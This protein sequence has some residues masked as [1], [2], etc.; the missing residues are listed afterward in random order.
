MR[1]DIK[2]HFVPGSLNKHQH[3]NKCR[4][5]CRARLSF[6]P[7]QSRAERRQLAG[8]NATRANTAV[9]QVAYPPRCTRKLVRPLSGE[10]F[11]MQ[12]QSSTVIAFSKCGA[13]RKIS[14]VK[15]EWH[16]LSAL[17]GAG[18]ERPDSSFALQLARCLNIRRYGLKQK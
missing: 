3:I 9:T 17:L 11:R 13:I 15:Y 7:V 10:G 4:S 5:R 1:I 16:G 8:A 2:S 6:W 18:V 12:T 14:A